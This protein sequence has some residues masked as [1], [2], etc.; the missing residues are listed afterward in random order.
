MRKSSDLVSLSIGWDAEP[1]MDNQP[2]REIPVLELASDH[3]SKKP[4]DS[5]GYVTYQVFLQAGRRGLT[6]REAASQIVNSGSGGFFQGLVKPRIKIG[7]LLRNNPYYFQA[8]E[9]RYILCE[10]IVGVTQ[11]VSCLQA[12]GEQFHSLAFERKERDISPS[13]LTDVRKEAA[14]MARRRGTAKYWAQMHANGWTRGSKGRH[15]NVGTRRHK[16]AGGYEEAYGGLATKSNEVHEFLGNQQG[17]HEVEGLVQA[18]FKPQLKGLL[19]N[20]VD[21]K[22]CKRSDG[23][24]WQCPLLAPSDSNY[25]EHHQKGMKQAAEIQRARVPAPVTAIGTKETVVEV[26]QP[27]MGKQELGKWE[28][29]EL[30]VHSG[31][32]QCLDSACIQSPRVTG[33]LFQESQS[34]QV[35]ESNSY[36]SIEEQAL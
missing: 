7:K 29:E 26:V 14:A 1:G 17:Q 11:A 4:V 5:L 15:E 19:K 18:H 27:H 36:L 3:P 35:V 10:A 9:G 34:W 12:P 23:K 16:I 24:N 25:C 30:P 33:Q 28:G 21:Q 20:A 8:G 13:T 2:A 6:A 22:P 32:N 31:N